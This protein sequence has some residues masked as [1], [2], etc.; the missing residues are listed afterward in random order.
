MKMQYENSRALTITLRSILLGSFFLI[1]SLFSLMGQSLGHAGHLDASFANG[2]I[3]T[4]NP[5]STTGA[6][7]IAL[8]S[9][10][11][12]ILGGEANGYGALLRVNSDGTIDNTFGSAGFVRNTFGLDGPKVVGL[13]VQPDDKILALAIGLPSY[14]VVGRFNGNGSVDTSFANQGFTAPITSCAPDFAAALRLQSDGEILVGC[15]FRM[16]RFTTTGQSDTAF[17]S[18]GIAPLKTAGPNVNSIAV[19]SDGKILVASS[20]IGFEGMLTRLNS[21]GSVD[22]S[23]AILGQAGSISP[24][25]AMVLQGDGRPVIAGNLITS[26]SPAANG[27]GVIR[28]NS[29]GS[30]DATFGSHGGVATSF[31]NLANAMASAIVQQLNGSLVV[32]GTA[33][34]QLNSSEFALV[35]YLSGGSLD[36]SFG[37][38]G[39]V[40]TSF[41]SS[42]GSVSGMVLQSDGKIVVAG[43]VSGSFAV[44][45]Y[46]AQ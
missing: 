17:G 23:F 25:N 6:T 16:A 7:S 42:A 10:G 45:R 14:V 32:A 8:Q 19:Q 40:L 37:T 5:G 24:T 46:F 12:I 35:R 21:D 22:S 28:F 31:P 33:Y 18:G 41:G 38:G 43:D 36:A 4:N 34:N 30:I 39:R 27:F 9:T 20:D 29:D 13:A 3:L 26:L 2:G 1:S 11:K 15:G 44:A